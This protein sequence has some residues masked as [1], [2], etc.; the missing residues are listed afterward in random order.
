MGEAY[1]IPGSFNLGSLSPIQIVLSGY[2][3]G[4]FGNTGDSKS[5]TRTYTLPSN[6]SKYGYWYAIGEVDFSWN[7]RSGG[8]YTPQNISFTKLWANPGDTTLKF[9]LTSKY[10]DTCSFSF[11]GDT[12]T[13]SATRRSS[14]YMYCVVSDIT[15]LSTQSLIS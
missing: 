11:T 4:R 1:L 13:F 8:T 10:S 3:S 6:V 15:I 9:S 14:P 5:Y 12:M 2:S 7:D